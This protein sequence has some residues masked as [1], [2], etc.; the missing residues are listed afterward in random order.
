METF[1]QDDKI[2][3]QFNQFDRNSIVIRFVRGPLYLDVTWHCAFWRFNDGNGLIFA[4]HC[5]YGNA[6]INSNKVRLVSKSL[7]LNSNRYFR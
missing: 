5:E 2:Y 3:N 4:S 1:Y 6:N 7:R